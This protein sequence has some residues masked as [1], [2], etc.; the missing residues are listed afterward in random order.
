MTEHA[1]TL[2]TQ[3]RRCASVR[4]T[5]GQVNKL[6]VMFLQ[7]FNELDPHLYSSLSSNRK[8]LMKKL[9]FDCCITDTTYSSDFYP[10]KTDREHAGFYCIFYLLTPKY[11]NSTSETTHSHTHI[12]LTHTLI[13]SVG[14]LM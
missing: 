2:H 4:T 6:F 3:S 5:S 11:T 14:T 1:G 13:R 12:H 7:V 9:V 10:S 8:D